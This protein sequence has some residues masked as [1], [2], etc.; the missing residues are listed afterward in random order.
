MKGL[1]VKDFYLV[2]DNL[3][4]LT[5][6]FIVM[7][8][9][10]SFLISPWVI[11]V[12]ATLMLSMLATHTIMGDKTSKWNKFVATLPVTTG[13]VIGS[14]YLLY[15]A[16]CMFGVISGGIMSS[17]VTALKQ[18]FDLRALLMYVCVGIVVALL[19]GSINIPCALLF[20]EEKFVLG[21][22]FSYIGATGL[23]I[24]YIL[25]VG[26]LVAIKT[27]MLAVFGGATLFSVI[28]FGISWFIS[29]KWIS[30]TKI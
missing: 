18:E 12:M 10:M 3:F 26:Q 6:V 28:V 20:N 19:S 2:K 14:K 17:T 8:A 24:A 29:A 1:L 13:Q 30:K 15:G 4:I 27:H 22:T 11:T 7:S 5:V 25:V 9:G 16:L 21:I 23:F